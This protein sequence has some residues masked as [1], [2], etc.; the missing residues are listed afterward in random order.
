MVWMNIHV[1]ENNSVK[2]ERKKQKKAEKST[3]VLEQIFTLADCDRSHDEQ[4][5]TRDLIFC[6][7]R[8]NLHPD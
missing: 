5:T 2:R 6:L 7:W 3:A 4:E 1:K 8:P